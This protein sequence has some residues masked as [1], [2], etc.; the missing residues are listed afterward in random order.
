M[1]IKPLPRTDLQASVIGLGTD[2]FGS[3]IDRKLSMQLL[4]RYVESGGNFIDTAEVYAGWI[5]GGE[6]QSEQLIGDWLGERG[7][8]D[9]R[10]IHSLFRPRALIRS[11]NRWTFRDC[12]S[13]KSNRT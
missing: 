4:D 6:H 10:A 5:P 1:Q 11:W 8:R 2:Y 7:S 9:T 12:P 13:A 3:T